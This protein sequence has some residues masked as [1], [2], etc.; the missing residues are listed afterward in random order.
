MYVLYGL[1]FMGADF[2]DLDI[3]LVE[4][5]LLVEPLDGSK[6]GCRPSEEVDDP[7]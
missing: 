4:F 7:D 5:V 3:Y 1:S 2:D 6:E